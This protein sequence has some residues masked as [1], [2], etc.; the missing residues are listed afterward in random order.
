ML[1]STPWH[2]RHHSPLS[3]L[4]TG[5][6]LFNTLRSVEQECSLRPKC[7]R[8]AFSP[9]SASFD[10]PVWDGRRAVLQR[11][12]VSCRLPQFVFCNP[13]PPRNLLL[14]LL[15]LLC[16]CT[17]RVPLLRLQVYPAIGSTFAWLNWM[18][19]S[20]SPSK[21]QMAYYPRANRCCLV[22]SANR[23]RL[24]VHLLARRSDMTIASSSI[25]CSRAFCQAQPLSSTID[26][27]YQQTPSCSKH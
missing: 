20:L 19:T 13:P 24:S 10:R 6:Y 27:L 17:R 1:R 8:G 7:Q 18:P 22:L 4:A 26:T 5:I 11:P 15:E 16:L 3:I 2:D 21:A 12:S 14:H 25:N 23:F 9:R